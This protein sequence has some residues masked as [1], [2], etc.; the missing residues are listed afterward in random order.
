MRTRHQVGQHQAQAGA[1]LV[2]LG[3]ERLLQRLQ[4]H[5]ID[6]G[7]VVDQ[8]Q[9]A[10]DR[11]DADLPRAVAHRV[12]EQIGQRG[13]EQIRIGG[14]RRGPCR[15][16]CREGRGKVQPQA[17][18][19]DVGQQLGRIHRPALDVHAG[20]EQRQQRG[21]HPRQPRGGLPGAL[22]ALVGAGRLRRAFAQGHRQLRVHAG[23]RGA[24]RVGR[25]R[26]H[27][28]LLAD[29][30][31]Q[32]PAQ[33]VDRVADRLQLHPLGRRQRGAAVHRIMVLHLGR[34]LVERQQLAPGAPAQRGRTADADQQRRHQ[35]AQRDIAQR[36]QPLL[37]RL[38]D[39]ENAPLAAERQAIDPPALGRMAQAFAVARQQRLGRRPRGADHHMLA[40]VDHLPGEAAAARR[41]RDGGRGLL[42]HRILGGRIRQQAGDQP[43]RGDQRVIEQLVDLVLD[44]QPDRQR[45][46]QA[47]GDG[48]PQQRRRQPGADRLHRDGGAAHVVASR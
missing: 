17:R 46:Q 38:G 36:L 4:P 3:V 33:L 28:A 40:P 45:G 29:A 5:R 44:H 18:H 26:D 22:Q 24:Q 14:Q 8:A 41:Q 6:A 47:P 35:R 15:A 31:R 19:R 7:A 10:V 20:A 16:L 37:A 43:G 34:E 21:H 13:G 25:M 48:D 12:V 23:Q 39:I 9:T 42:Q 27:R 32:A 2:G 1:A 30:L 11:L